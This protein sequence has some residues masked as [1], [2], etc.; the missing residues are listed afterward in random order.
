MRLGM[1]DTSRRDEVVKLREA[2]LTY[3]EIGRRWGITHKRARQLAKEKP[4]R[5]PDLYSR[6]MLTTQ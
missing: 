2:G 3:A 6:V 5:K 1:I 4:T